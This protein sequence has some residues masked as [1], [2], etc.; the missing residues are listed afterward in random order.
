V[1]VTI[2]G[3]LAVVGALIAIGIWLD[4]RVSVLPRPE[5]LRDAARPK[6]PG[7]EHAAGTAPHTALRLGE[8]QLDTVLAGQRCTC[9]VALV[10]DPPEELVFDGRA[11]R[12]I[13][14]RCPAC[15]AA[16]SIY[17]EPR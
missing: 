7:S 12:S 15:G 6:L 5:A 10:G 17:V 4:R 8:A 2:L 1:V 16:R 11:L 9:G 13:R 14:L 3:S